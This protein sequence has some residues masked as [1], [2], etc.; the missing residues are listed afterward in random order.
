MRFK[1]PQVRYSDTPEPVTPYQAA[2]QVWDQRIG[3]ARVQAK[4]WRL[5]AFGSLILSVGFAA[6]LVWPLLYRI[7]GGLP[8]RG[9]TLARAAG[10]MLVGFV[11]WF[12]F[13]AGC[14]AFLMIQYLTGGAWGLMG[15]RV[16]EAA[17][18]TLPFMALLFV[19]ILL[20]GVPALY[21]W[22]RPEAVS[23]P[24][25]QKKA[26]YLNVTGFTMRAIGYFVIWILLASILSRWSSEQDKSANPEAANKRCA[27]LS[28]PGLVLY[29]LSITF[30]SVDWLMSLEPHWF[31]TLYGG[32]FAGGQLLSGV[33]FTIVALVTLANR[34]PL[35]SSLGKRHFHDLGKLLLAFVMLWAYLSF[36]QFLIIWS[37]NLAEEVPFY[38]KRLEGG[39]QVVAILL[40]V[41]H[42]VIPFLILLSRDLKRHPRRLMMVAL[43]ILAMRFVDIEYLVRPAVAAKLSLSA[44]VGDIL[45]T[46]LIGLLWLAY[47][48]YQLLKRP[49]LPQ[50]DP[51]FQEAVEHGKH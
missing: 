9:Y 31:S 38:L 49:L 34:E 40:I 1:R 21:E 41:A 47:F 3:S 36:S 13:A 2:A 37:G 43:F 11:F 42:F 8:D 18:R 22:A 39:W 50:R 10:L 6:A 7:L 4:N 30:A 15:R 35:A 27:V 16:F 29:G 26:A 20:F 19:P 45:V 14:L 24:L 17:S 12:H 46:A 48:R 51:H 28:G 25:I 5:M 33:A 32:L 23:D 44:V